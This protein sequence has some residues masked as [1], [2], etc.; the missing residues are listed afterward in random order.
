[1][2]IKDR[3]LKVIHI[4]TDYKFVSGS[5]SFDGEIF[6]NEVIIFQN[7]ESYKGKIQ[8]KTILLKTTNRDL[9]KAVKICI[10]SDLVVLYDLNNIKCRIALSLPSNIKIAWR[11]FGYELYGRKKEL[12]L[13]E[14]SLT[15]SS[16][17]KKVYIRSLLKFYHYLKYKENLN[18]IF[19][20]A[21]KRINYMLVLSN[22]EYNFLKDNWNNLPEFIKLPHRYFEE[23]LRIPTAKKKEKNRIP[24]IVIGNNRSSYNN[25][26]DVI[27]LVDN[28]PAKSNYNFTLLFNYGPTGQ[29]YKAVKNKVQNKPYYTLIDDFI[30]PDEFDNFYRNISTLVINGYR[31]MAVANILL[32]IRNG[33][34]VYL[35][36]KNI[37]KKWLENEGISVFSITDLDKDLKDGNIQLNYDIAHK[38]LEQLK[39]FS[40][41]YTKEDFQKVMYNKIVDKSL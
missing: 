32:A 6:D 37:L 16:Q 15:N 25:H 26:L 4:H 17:K 1:M 22:E 38:N 3:K 12:F 35:N 19:D 31:Q 14:K 24:N 28:N 27:E 2:V 10:N 11:F 21:V 39:K 29:Y 23:T 40:E 5:N 13:S 7:K 36:D 8:H 18:Y 20:K 30:P 41:R 9:N 33:V 34:K